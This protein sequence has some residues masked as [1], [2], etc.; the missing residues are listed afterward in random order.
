LQPTLFVPQGTP[1]I[2]QPQAGWS[3]GSFPLRP[4]G[5]LGKKRTFHR[6][7]RKRPI[8][9]S[10]PDT[11]CLANFRCSFGAK[12]GTPVNFLLKIFAVSKSR[13]SFG[14]LFACVILASCAGFA[15]LVA[16]VS[17]WLSI[18]PGDVVA[19][20]AGFRRA[21]QTID[22]EKLR[23]WA[24]KQ[25]AKK[26][27]HGDLIPQT[28]LPD[29]IYKLYDSPPDVCLSKGVGED[30]VMLIWG[31]GFFHWGFHIGST[32]LVLRTNLA[33]DDSYAVAQWVPGIYYA[34]EDTRHKI[35]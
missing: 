7:F 11:A 19:A 8:I 30:D 28:E 5:T 9:H 34:R 2:S 22:P 24:L 12:T 16:G 27:G 35:Q 17:Y 4:E 3:A 21:K 23:E 10:P 14:R 6:A 15:C 31:G 32:N 13:K 18:T 29:Y 20:D 25:I 1:E 26:K 33:P